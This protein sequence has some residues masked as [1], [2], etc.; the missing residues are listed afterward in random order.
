MLQCSIFCNLLRTFAAL[1]VPLDILLLTWGES[2]DYE[3]VVKTL[4]SG[5]S[6]WINFFVL[7]RSGHFHNVVLMFTYV[8]KTDAENKLC[9]CQRWN[10]Q[11]WFDVVNFNV[12]I[13]NVVSTLIWRCPTSRRRIN[14]NTTLKQRWNVCWYIFLD[15]DVFWRRK[16][17]ANIFFLI[18]TS[19]EGE[20]KRRLQDVFIKTNVCWVTFCKLGIPN[21]KNQTKFREE[22]KYNTMQPSTGVLKNTEKLFTRT[23]LQERS[24]VS[25]VGRHH[26]WF[27]M[28]FM[29]FFRNPFYKEPPSECLWKI[30]I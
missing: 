15:Q 2:E 12:E 29:K 24:F 20:G 16:A 26:R 27:P 1:Q 21:L 11:R 5:Y 8:V 25:N 7:C 30:C 14:Q 23:H 18:K 4:N 6:I 10:T 13:H 19:S 3:I 28:K 17:K 22:K 9:L